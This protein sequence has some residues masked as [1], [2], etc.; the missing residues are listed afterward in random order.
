VDQVKVIVRY[1]DGR[2]VKGF[3][4]DFFPNKDRFHLQMLGAPS[5][6]GLELIL[7]KDLKALFFVKDFGGDSSYKERK[8][9][10]E[11]ERVQGRK[12]EVSFKD[13][14]KL[15]GT[16]LGYDPQR[17]GFFFVPVDGKSNNIRVFAV[18]SA[19]DSVHYL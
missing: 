18:Q 13:G 3:T 19:V 11:G 15:V 8:A 12:V 2:V 16:T 17:P 14:E 10:L 5:G 1:A 9:F 6:N 4:G 7:L